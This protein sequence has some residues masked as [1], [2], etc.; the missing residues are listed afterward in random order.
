MVE[1][2]PLVIRRETSTHTQT[3]SQVPLSFGLPRL[4]LLGRV[5]AL[6]M[7]IT[8][9]PFPTRWFTRHRPVLY[10]ILYYVYI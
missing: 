4:R 9:H 7:V 5:S 8:R 3:H 10:T 2:F 6:T 1:R